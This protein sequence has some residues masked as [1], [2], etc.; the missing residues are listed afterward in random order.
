MNEN[1]NSKSKKRIIIFSMLIIILVIMIAFFLV[2]RLVN[3]KK[4]IDASD[5]HIKFA[6]V[7]CYNWGFMKYNDWTERIYELYTDGFIK[8]TIKYNYDMEYMGNEMTEIEKTAQLDLEERISIN[9]FLVENIVTGKYSTEGRKTIINNGIFTDVID[10]ADGTGWKITYY[11]P[12]SSMNASFGPGY[13]D[14]KMEDELIKVFTNK[15]K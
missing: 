10:G 3:Y 9:R 11:G 7:E 6:E 8:Y 13:I 2:P 5:K 15:I 4:F 14:D 1:S 12:D